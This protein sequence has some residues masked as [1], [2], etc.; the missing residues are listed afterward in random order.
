MSENYDRGKVSYWRWTDGR[1]GSGYKILY[2][3]NFLID[4]VVIY[5]PQGSHIKPHTDPV[6]KGT[7]HRINLVLWKAKK[8]G[9]FTS[10]GEIKPKFLTQRFIYFRPDI[11]T[12]AVSTIQEGQRWVLSI[13]W[14]WP[15]GK[16]D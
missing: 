6:S 13:G 3:W 10:A 1:Q 14:N 5:F 7:H 8:G 12:H 4:L 11:T 2:L 16:D 15:W 9:R